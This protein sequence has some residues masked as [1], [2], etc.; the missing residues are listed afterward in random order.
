MLDATGC[1]KSYGGVVAL[2][3][4]VWTFAS[5]SSSALSGRTAPARLRCSIFSLASNGPSAGDSSCAART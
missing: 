5:T 3:I 4:S 1:R 2:K